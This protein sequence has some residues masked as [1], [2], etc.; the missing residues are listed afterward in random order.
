MW[1]VSSPPAEE[2]WR[3]GIGW[4]ETSSCAEISL[5]WTNP[6]SAGF[7]Q[8]REISVWWVWSCYGGIFLWWDMQSLF[9]LLIYRSHIRWFSTFLCMLSR[10][11]P[12]QP[13]KSGPCLTLL[14]HQPMVCHWMLATCWPNCSSTVDWCVTSILTSPCGSYDWCL[15]HV[16]CN[17]AL[18]VRSRSPLICLEKGSWQDAAGF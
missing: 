10:R 14:W 13:R 7:V 15:P 6:A 2:V 1:E 18:R 12:A 16:P 11:N 5:P 8:G 4:V 3:K 9:P 17:W